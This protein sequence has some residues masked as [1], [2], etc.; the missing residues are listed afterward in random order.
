MDFEN[1]NLT[2]DE[3]Q[4]IY[5]NYLHIENE[6]DSNMSDT[7]IELT[8]FVLSNISRSN[9][10]RLILP[11]LWNESIKHLLPN[12]YH[13][14]SNILNSIKNKLENS[15]KLIQYDSAI[16]EQIDSGIL[17]RVEDLS[18]LKKSKLHSFLPHSAVFKPGSVS[19]KCRIVLLSN[20][21]EKGDGNTLS[22]NQI[23]L[24]GPQLNNKLLTTLI[25]YRFNKYLIIT[26]IVKA[27][28]QLC[29]RPQDTSKLHLLWYKDVHSHNFE[30]VAYK[31]T[32]V[33]MGLR[34]SP[35][36]L[37]TSL[38]YI[39]VHNNCDNDCS[40]VFEMTYNLSYMDNIAFSS[41]SREGAMQGFAKIIRVFKEYKL[42]LQKCYANFSEFGEF[43]KLLDDTISLTEN[44]LC[45]LFGITWNRV[46]DT[47]CPNFSKMNPEIKTRRQILS[48]INSNFDPMGMYL[49]TLNRAKLFLHNLN[50]T[51]NL[52][53]DENIDCNNLN[54]WKLIA[55]QFN[56]N[57]N[58]I[59]FSIP[60]FVGNYNASYEL[61][62]FVDASKDFYGVVIYIKC[63]NDENLYFLVGKNK[64]V[65]KNL[66]GKSIPILE[67][68]A[69]ECG[70]MCLNEIKNELTNAYCPIQINEMH[71]YSDS[72]VAL[73][74]VESKVVKYDKIEKKS[75]LINN[76][77][78]N[79]VKCCMSFPVTFHH[80]EGIYNPA[81]KVTRS[82]SAR[83]LI[84][85]NY[86]S[87]PNIE[88]LSDVVR[89]TVPHNNAEIIKSVCMSV[90]M[91][92]EVCDVP[93]IPFD[94]YSS[95]N[96]LCKV[97]HWVRLFVYKLKCKVYIKKGKLIE[98]SCD[99]CD[100]VSHVIRQAQLVDFGQVLSYFHDPSEDCPQLIGQLNLFLDKN[101][102][103]RVKGKMANMPA[104]LDE[105]YPVLISKH[106]KLI[107][108]LVYDYHLKMRHAGVYKI[109]NS[110]RKNFY[111][112]NSYNTVRK[113]LKSC[114]PCKKLYGKTVKV[115]QSPYRDF[116][117]D[118]SQ[119][120]FRTIALD[121]IGPFTVYDPSNSK[122][123]VYLLIVTCLYTRAINL[124]VCH[125]V[126]N[127][128][129]FQAFQQH[130]HEYGV[131]QTIISD[132]GSPI[133]SSVKQIQKY[134]ADP[135][136]VNFLKERNIN[137]LEFS[138]YPAGASFLGGVVESLVKQVK[139]L[140]YS[141][142]GKR[143]LN[144]DEFY[145][146]TSECK[147]LVNK[148]PIGYRDSLREPGEDFPI[149][150]P[151]LLL[152]G[153][154]V[155]FLAIIPQL[156]DADGDRD[157]RP[158]I[159]GNTESLFESFKKLRNCKTELNKLYY[160]EFIEN[161]R[162]QSLNKSARYKKISH[163]EVNEGDL[164]LIRQEMIKPYFHPLGVVL[165]VT[166]NG[167]GECVSVTLRKANREIITRHVSDLVLL[168][169]RGIENNTSPECVDHKEDQ[170]RKL[171]RSAALKCIDSINSLRDANLL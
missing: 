34:F 106:S 115:N 137:M 85:S 23:S 78:D 156:N 4:N 10:G 112:P 26:D 132:N 142:I 76:K 97:T 110:L 39:L 108:S 134:F 118:P 95:F 113:I 61:F 171:K 96:K 83:L 17:E 133:T 22:H 93:L 152:K 119:R 168:E 116:R 170:H 21:C 48:N 144:L 32:R 147:M 3:L 130:V 28:L 140:I 90:G 27:F 53:W 141:S 40:D 101:L 94:R 64:I 164:V 80:I 63:T 43:L 36:L 102:L 38:Y 54:Q 73:S 126:D 24:P 138:P 81:D 14:S 11:A 87:G 71:L 143:Y 5:N 6:I 50:F 107:P 49:P 136:I 100:S 52:A 35:F 98:N 37:M 77:L 31:Y 139:H 82:V 8:E 2:N 41:S 122:I 25:L 103:I 154:D 149:I 67:L 72:M 131:S 92:S 56:A 167:L 42:E 169:S 55:N 12:N 70:I 29:L 117:I 166:R 51:Q 109:L 44:D 124:L 20:L 46:S 155:D 79:L 111:I 159:A 120:P 125:N 1:I 128:S 15:P 18:K 165:K 121:H 151:E 129:F 123:K 84:N 86:L 59:Q 19:T 60:R 45:N 105:K 65:S 89:F 88:Q 160:S 7:N 158:N 157:Y 16:Q 104:D 150:T 114:I 13:L 146:I 74:W 47:Y 30:E 9:D 127:K 69:I 75:I 162:L 148:R 68:V 91:R 66:L 145:F 33:P 99:Y 57:I 62:A 163:T 58:K 153:Y 135:E 161:L